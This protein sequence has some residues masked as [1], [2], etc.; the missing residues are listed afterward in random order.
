MKIVI[1]GAGEVGF[2]L[3]RLL[4][5]EMQDIVLI[6][7]DTKRLEYAGNHID[8]ITIKGNATSPKILEESNV[9]SADM[10]IAVTSNESTNMTIAM[11]GKQ[12]G[13][14]STFARINNNE[15]LKD[16]TKVDFQS[17]GIDFMI[18]PEDLAAVEISHLVRQ[19]A[20]TDTFEFDQGELHLI[21][22]KLEPQASIINKTIFET[23]QLNPELSFIPVAIQRDNSTIIPRGSTVF[24]EGDQVFFISE[25][26]GI[27]KVI[28]LSGKENLDI[29]NIMI[30]GGSR[31]GYLSSQLLAKDYD[32]KIVEVD[33]E[34]CMEIADRLSNILVIQ[35]DGRDVE[36]LEE[37]NLESM[38]SF[39]AVTGNS[40]TN[41]MSCLVA[42]ARGVKQTI[43]LVENMDYINLS[44]TIGIDTMINKK[45]IA[46]GN[47]FRHIRQGDVLTMANIHGVEAE[48]LEFEVKPGSKITNKEIKDLGFPKTAIIGGVVRDGTGVIAM[49]DF[50]VQA[51]DHVVVFALPD[52]IKK[53]ESF[54]K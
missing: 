47:I 52:A 21:G 13:A 45:L 24:I 9:A 44:K 33:E 53:V 28:R 15:F 16:D 34:R 20:F 29:E 41:I 30:L 5:Y 35:G 51:G 4:S 23:A 39:I 1:A 6:D 31:I 36:L 7:T 19:S 26:S 49:G 43:A 40:E 50:R 38:D 2:H 37:E 48:V 8:V 10:L 46:A 22:I 54:F 14:H 18:S 25:K 32:L 3:A 27:E 17:L 42:K 11:I 12:L